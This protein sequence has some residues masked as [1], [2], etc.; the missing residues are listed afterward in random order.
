MITQCNLGSSIRIYAKSK[1]LI[2]SNSKYIPFKIN[3]LIYTTIL[4]IYIFISNNTKL[5]IAKYIIIPTNGTIIILP[6]I[7]TIGIPLKL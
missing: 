5:D 6:K 4:D 1:L 7:E 2:F 3:L